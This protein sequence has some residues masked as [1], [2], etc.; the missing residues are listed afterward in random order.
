MPYNPFHVSTDQQGSRSSKLISVRRSTIFDVPL[1]ALEWGAP[2]QHHH[3]YRKRARSDNVSQYQTSKKSGADNY[4]PQQSSEQPHIK[5]KVRIVEKKVEPVTIMGVAPLVDDRVRYVVEF[6]LSHV[7]S[8]NVEVEAKLGILNER[9]QGVRAVDLVPVLCETPIRSESNKDTRFQSDIGGEMFRRLNTRLNRRIEETEA[10]EHGR[11]HYLR[12]HECDVFWPGRIRET[13]ERRLAEDGT[14]IYETIRVQSK[15]RLGD[16]NVLCPA[17]VADVRYSASAEEDCS[18]PVNA[19]SDMRR[20]KDRISYK[21]E[22]VSVDI[23]CVETTKMLEPD[24]STTTFEV[25]VEIDRSACLYEE[26]MKY[27]QR[28]ETSKLFDIA[29]S[30]V[31]TVRLLLDT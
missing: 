1:Q 8:P 30:M 4:K 21:Y 28:D 5:E 16:L 14:E 24:N 2:D 9:E 15:H 19:R 10:F 22:Y 20:L 6:I 11:V 29:T 27:R 3:T 12:T 25:E 26:V 17:N 7:D 13:K 23:T 31:N 18:V